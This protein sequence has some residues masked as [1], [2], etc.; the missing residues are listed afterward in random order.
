MIA[1]TLRRWRSVSSILA[2]IGLSACAS[3]NIAS[4]P[5]DQPL[6]DLTNKDLCRTLPQGRLPVS[7][8]CWFIIQPGVRYDQAG[9]GTG[10]LVGANEHY[11]VRIH[12]DQFWYDLDRRVAAPGG[13]CGGGITKLLGF[14]KHHTEHKWFAL[15]AN[16]RPSLGD[17]KTV[18][19]SATVPRQITKENGMFFPQTSGELYFYVNDAAWFYD[20]N[21][22]RILVEILRWPDGVPPAAQGQSVPG[23]K[24][25]CAESK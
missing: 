24:I 15:L 11:E 3:V 6:P 22:G 7:Q 19:S 20:N 1:A 8:S 4:L 23:S 5:V 17:P 10:L 13:D 21:S 16:L 9:N 2:G 12:G 25:Q 14:T 18:V